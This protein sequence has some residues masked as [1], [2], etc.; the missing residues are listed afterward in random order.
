MT[1]LSEKLWIK[2]N[3]ELFM[4]KLTVPDLY[5]H[6][7]LWK[8]WKMATI[9]LISII[10]KN[11]SNYQ[12]P[13][14]LGL[15]FSFLSVDGNRISLENRRC[16]FSFFLNFPLV[17]FAHHPFWVPFQHLC[18]VTLKTFM[19]GHLCVSGLPHESPM[20]SFTLPDIWYF[21]CNFMKLKFPM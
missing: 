10:R 11:F 6:Q 8:N 14:S 17:H 9:L 15:Q 3:F 16:K 19:R 18:V 2:W 7:P 1:K 20:C 13:Q 5:Q 12:S 21:S 4:F